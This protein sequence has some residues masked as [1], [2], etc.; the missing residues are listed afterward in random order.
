MKTDE[1]KSCEFD[2]LLTAN[3]DRYV[4]DSAIGI[5]FNRSLV[6]I[7]FVLLQVTL[8]K[9]LTKCVYNGFIES[10]YHF[11]VGYRYGVTGRDRV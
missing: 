3:S 5:N 9:C 4:I 6:E 11:S 8:I 7:I 2:C 10:F 1:E